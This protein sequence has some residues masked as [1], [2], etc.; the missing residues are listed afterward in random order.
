MSLPL[1]MRW[2][3][4]GWFGQE[5]QRAGS[6]GR[7]ARDLAAAV[8]HLHLHLVRPQH[9]RFARQPAGRGER[10]RSYFRVAG[11][12]DAGQHVVVAVGREVH[13]HVERGHRRLRRIRG[14]DQPRVGLRG[15]LL[16]LA[17]IVEIGPQFVGRILQLAV[18]VDVAAVRLGGLD[19]ADELA[20]RAVVFQVDH[21]V[22]PFDDRVVAGQ[23]APWLEPDLRRVFVVFQAPALHQH[24]FRMRPLG[25]PFEPGVPLHQ[26]LMA[27]RIVE[28]PR[29]AAVAVLEDEARRLL[30]LHPPRF[31][32]QIHARRFD[33]DRRVL[34]LPLLRD[35]QRDLHLA[36]RAQPVFRLEERGRRA[37]HQ[38]VGPPRLAVDLHGH[39]PE[40]DA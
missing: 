1:R 38:V 21:R 29:R 4:V 19:L 37:L 10:P 13:L 17:G 6:G 2:C 7:H 40:I 9:V 15:D 32:V 22:L 34:R 20:A 30:G 35:V 31:G 24:G 16:H 25:L 33:G 23:A 28:C 8:A 26:Q 14:G 18:R 5:F 12:V 3:C 39:A 27:Q 11:G 36:V